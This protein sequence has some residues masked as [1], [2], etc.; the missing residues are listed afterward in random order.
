MLA[1]VPFIRNA[2]SVRDELVR[3][4]NIVID[5]LVVENN[6]PVTAPDF[7]TYFKQH[8]SELSDDVHPNG[9]GCQAMASLWFDGLIASGL[10]N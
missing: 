6:L 5:E 3:D 4:Y 2:P 8:P 7:Y 10:F 1:K 9:K